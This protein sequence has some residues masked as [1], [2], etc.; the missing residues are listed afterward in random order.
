M[1]KKYLCYFRQVAKLAIARR[2]IQ[3]FRILCGVNRHRKILNGWSL[4]TTTPCSAS[5]SLSTLLAVMT[6]M[7][8]MVYPLQWVNGTDAI[9]RCIIKQVID[10]E[11][12][13]NHCTKSGLI[14]SLF[15]HALYIRNFFSSLGF[16][17]ELPSNEPPGYC[18]TFY[19]SLFGANLAK[20]WYKNLANNLSFE[21]S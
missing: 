3:Y 8:T 19:E 16:E 1:L 21:R 5:Q 15:N 14:F 2:H 6:M 12:Q 18:T 10:H 20:C 7:T 11:A 4:P 9:T 17:P 13:S